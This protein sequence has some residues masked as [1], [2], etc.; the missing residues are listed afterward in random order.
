MGAAI[1]LG[2]LVGL[3]SGFFEGWPAAI[4]FRVT[5]PVAE[6]SIAPTHGA[7]NCFGIGIEEEL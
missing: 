2:T 7:G 6:Q 5:D 4:L 1:M 3:M